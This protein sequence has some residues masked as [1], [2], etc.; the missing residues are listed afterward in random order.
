MIKITSIIAKYTDVTTKEDFDTNWLL[1]GFEI[2]YTFHGLAGTYFYG[3]TENISI[4]EIKE[5]IK[6]YLMAKLN[7]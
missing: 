6:S 7:T 2:N 1:R 4:P 3:E 5:L